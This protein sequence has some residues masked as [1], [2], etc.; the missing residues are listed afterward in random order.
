[1]IAWLIVLHVLAA[2]FWVGASLTLLV[3][4]VPAVQLAGV[5]APVFMQSL[6]RGARLQMALAVAG[7]T[8]ILSGLAALWI[9]SG[10]FN[11]GFM[12]S[13][14]GILISC[15]AASG[16]LAIVFGIITGRL[17]RRGAPFAVATNALLVIAL[18]C[19]VLGAHA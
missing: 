11:H 16:I 1:M 5:D 15:G 6:M 19:M 10:G 8:T 14:N 2:A 17:Q 7:L 9:V 3:F 12:G 13:T 18:V 4:V